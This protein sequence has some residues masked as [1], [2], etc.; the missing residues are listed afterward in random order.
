MINPK[1]QKEHKWLDRLVGEWTTETNAP[2]MNGQPPT[3]HTGTETVRSLEG[4]WFVAE[5]KGDMGPT[6]MTLGYDPEKKKYVGSFV[7]SMMTDQWIYEGELDSGGK[8]L[9]LETE[10]PSYSGDGSRVPYKD[11]M[12]FL[13]DDHRVLTSKMQGPDAQW[14]EFM[15]SDYRRVK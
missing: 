7:G 8:V 2:A 12:E 6:I 15:R 4:I 5:G 14:T 10:G 11:S 1:P 13:D 9:V 3:K